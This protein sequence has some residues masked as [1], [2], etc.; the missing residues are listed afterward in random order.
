MYIVMDGTLGVTG[1]K[2]PSPPEPL[3]GEEHI[4]EDARLT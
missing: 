2:A 3:K 4:A 1:G